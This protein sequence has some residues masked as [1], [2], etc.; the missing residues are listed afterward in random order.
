M[1]NY[2]LFSLLC[3]SIL[4]PLVFSF[5]VWRMSSVQLARRW[6]IWVFAFS[7]LASLSAGF[8]VANSTDTQLT[9]S[10]WQ[11]FA[12]DA[13]SAIPLALFMALCLGV[14]VLAPKHKLTPQWFAGILWLS[15]TTSAAYAANNLLIFAFGWA[16]SLAPFL[17]MRSFAAPALG[18]AT[19]GEKSIGDK[20]IPFFSK[21]VLWL[22]LVSLCGG[23]GC[24]IYAAPDA[25][26]QGAL[27]LTLVRQGNTWLLFAAFIFLMG[28]VILRKGLFPAHSW[29]V[30]AYEHGPLLPLTL[31]VNDHLGAF[32]VARIVLP[33]LPNQAH[34]DWPIFSNLSLLTAAY[35]AVLALAERKPRRLFALV[36]IS[37]SAF[38]LTGLE[39]YNAVGIT[40][41]LVLW[42]VVSVSTT[43]LAAVYTGLEAR[44]GT[45]LE[46]NKFLGLAVGAPRLAFFFAAGCLALVGLPLTLGFPAEDLLMQGTLATN[47][48]LGVVLPVVTALNA[49]SVVRLF[50]RLFLGNPVAAAHHVEDAL[51]RERWVLTVAFLF[52]L[53]GGLFPSQLVRLPAVAAE[54]LVNAVSG[55]HQTA[56]L[57]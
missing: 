26:W 46:T 51:V 34:S 2:L 43:M 45:L 23:V 1:S 48:Y 54:R 40:G 11:W 18:L 6:S 14:S 53:I 19:N 49:F 31:M 13:L 5:V 21:A 41:A 17:V 37:Q 30:T 10:S 56:G 35:A 20:T 32:L 25:S 29:V 27:G 4:T 55:S 50:A 42:Q 9:D 16:G 12:I 3:L 47:P 44:L 28:A 22:S 33:L 8:S 7:L 39:S 57:P 38:L 52:L 15:A 24:L 36:A